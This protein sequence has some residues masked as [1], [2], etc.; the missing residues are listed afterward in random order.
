MSLPLTPERWQQIESLYHEAQERPAPER[1]AWL[2]QA[3]AGDEALRGEVEKLLVADESASGFMDAPAW[4]AEARK[5]S[6]EIPSESLLVDS[7]VGQQ[8]SH[9]KIISRL[10]AGGMGEVYL[11][12]DLALE[13]QVAIKVL[14]AAFT[15]DAERVQRFVRE[16]KAA[17]A[18]NHPNIITIHE[19]GQAPLAGG[20][21]QYATHFIVTELVEGETLRQRLRQGPLPRALALDLTAQVA[22]A[23]AAAHKAGIIHRDIKPENVMVRPDGLVKVLDFGLAKLTEKTALMSGEVD[24][25]ALTLQHSISTPGTTP[26]TVMGTLNYMSP[27]Q[28]RGEPVDARSDLFSVGIVLCELLTGKAP[29]TRKT[30]ADIIAAILEHTPPPLTQTL[31]DAPPELAELASQLLRK[32]KE[33]RWP[34]AVTLADEL[35]RL[36]QQDE[37]LSIGHQPSL[38]SAEPRLTHSASAAVP[39]QGPTQAITQAMGRPRSWRML[40]AGLALGVLAAAVAYFG[41]FRWQTAEIDSLAIMPLANVGVEPELEYIADGLTEGFISKLSQLPRLR[42][43]SRNAVFRYKGKPLDAREIGQQFNVRAAL[44][45][46]LVK[47]DQRF[48]IKLDLVDTKNE[49]I[50]WTADFPFINLGD[51][52]AT[53]T[54]IIQQISGRLRAQ[55]S[56][57]EGQQL[58]RQDTRDPEA[59]QLFLQG[60]FYREKVTAENLDKS[61]TFYRQAIAKDP[62]YALAYVELANSYLAFS[63]NFRPP[64]TVMPQAL[65]NVEIA[66]QKD[67]KLAAA[68]STRATIQRSYE[69]DFAKTEESCRRA[70]ELD[71]ND[72]YALVQTGFLLQHQGHPVAALEPFQKALKLDPYALQAHQ[73]LA[74]AYRFARQYDEAFGIYQ[75]A[76]ALEPTFAI[77]HLNSAQI[78]GLKREYEKALDEIKQ[79][80]LT[81]KD[82]PLVPVYR[83]LIY[84]QMKRTAEARQLLAQVTASPKYVRPHLIAQVYAVLGQPNEAFAWLE[85]ADKERGTF[86]LT[87]NVEPD[88][89]NL[90]TDPRY[91][92]LLRRLNLTL[93]LKEENNK[94]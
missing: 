54:K 2:A 77:N 72:A 3:C 69:R 47:R 5:L 13:R 88:F 91:A 56:S 67:P 21:T 1:A 80:E 48:T 32:D 49:A 4:Q 90:R 22:A 74:R 66:L 79:A 45:G 63:S 44:I 26:G 59:Y 7:F 27:E 93:P 12:H 50:L 39:T 65:E 92:D 51:T 68:Y 36:K 19:I 40:L 81:M 94:R 64:E 58:A 23:L 9:Y 35:K 16:A 62:D 6:A 52:L 60:R 8:F 20:A 25:E 78:Y 10:G 29:F 82:D 34:S 83:S 70:L 75:K 15:R 30:Q 86:I 42:V 71:P 85:K 87:I 11:A 89:E 53:Q 46:E 73:N 14:P 18:L 37:T 33:E 43:L 28:V 76:L 24:S 84:A 55:L 61:I 31:P 41:Y 17:S 38:S 57:T